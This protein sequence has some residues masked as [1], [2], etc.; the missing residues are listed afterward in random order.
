MC[1]LVGFVG[2]P[3]AE[4]TLKH[5]RLFLVP[6]AM[7]FIPCALFLLQYASDTVDDSREI[8]SDQ[9]QG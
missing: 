1:G 8:N 3:G 5:R 2:A 6:Q 7:I 4:S 9:M